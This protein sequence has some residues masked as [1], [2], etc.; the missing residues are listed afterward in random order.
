M[1]KNFYITGECKNCHMMRT[2]EGH[3]PCIANLPGVLYACCGHGITNGY[4]K[5][6][7][8]RCFNFKPTSVDLDIPKHKDKIRNVPVY[9]ESEKP[10]VFHFK[11]RKI[12]KRSSGFADE[13]DRHIVK[14]KRTLSST[15]LPFM[16]IEIIERGNTPL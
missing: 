12:R 14:I 8:G 15:D 9:V 10:K 3:D 6:E 11:S 13:K 2:P 1:S 5:F 7:D 4:I 16:K